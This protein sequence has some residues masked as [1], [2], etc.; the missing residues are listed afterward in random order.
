MARYLNWLGIT[1]RVFNVGNYRR[2]FCGAELPHDFFDP[3]NTQ[4]EEQ[5]ALA[6]ESALQDMIVWLQETDGQ[7]AIYDATN[8][9]AARREMIQAACRAAD[10]SVCLMSLA[11]SHKPDFVYRVNLPEQRNHPRQH[12]RGKAQQS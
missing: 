5:R 4:A 7:V 2:R 12:S 10:I 6:A 11:Q 9:T 1:T 8:T 3:K